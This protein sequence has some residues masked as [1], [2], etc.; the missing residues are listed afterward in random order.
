MAKRIASILIA[1]AMMVIACMPA[2]FAANGFAL[3]KSTPVNGYNRVQAQNVMLKLYFSDEVYD[4]KTQAANKDK[5][6]FTDSNG[7]NVKYKIYYDE[8][9]KSKISIL[10]VNDL[11]MEETYTLTISGDLI[12]D[13]GQTLGADEVIKF[14]TKSAGGGMVYGLLM[15]A[16]I[17]VMVFI[18]I[19]DQR[20]IMEEEDV[21]SGVTIQTNPYKLAKEK[22]IS[23]DEASK[24]I[25]KEKEKAAKKEEKRRQ[26]EQAAYEAKKA[27]EEASRNIYRVHTK[28]IVKRKK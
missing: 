10:S 7:K 22:G 8:S 21:A 1:A 19:R 6:K 18:T 24:I 26:K 5:F 9:D 13:D 17:V 15:V 12:D 25:A 14:T 2:A 4:S 20:K 23:V 28:R 16:M 27:A 11:K 3:E